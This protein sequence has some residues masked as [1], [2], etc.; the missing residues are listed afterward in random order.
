[1]S[2]E[3][4]KQGKAL[5]IKQFRLGVSLDAI[6]CPFT[7]QASTITSLINDVMNDEAVKESPYALKLRQDLGVYKNVFA[8]FEVEEGDLQALRTL[9]MAAA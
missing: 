2:P 8:M 5:V 3:Q 1:M 4:I 9:L 6:L 7:K